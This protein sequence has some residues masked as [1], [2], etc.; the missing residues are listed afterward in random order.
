MKPVVAAV[1]AYPA[2]SAGSYPATPALFLASLS[3]GVWLPPL[4]S[5]WKRAEKCAIAGP[6]RLQ[7]P[8]ARA[9]GSRGARCWRALVRQ[10]LA[11]GCT[12][13]SRRHHMI[14]RA[15]LVSVL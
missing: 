1:T 13:L 7:V 6:D 12:N 5:G 8:E 3:C 15:G 9:A 2:P 4:L 14:A 11:A 10:V